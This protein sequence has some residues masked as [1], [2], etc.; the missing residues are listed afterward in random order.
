MNEDRTPC[1]VGVGK[2]PFGPLYR[3]LDP[4]RSAYGLAAEALESALADAGMERQSIDSVIVARLPSY[5]KFCADFGLT[6]VRYANF[7]SGGG[8]QSGL[9][10]L[11]AVA[12]I[13]S[14]QA[15]TVAC[16]YGNN[17][18]SVRV[19]YGGAPTPTSRYDDPYGMTSNG[20]Y[21]AMMFRRHQHEFG[22]PRE[23]LAELA[24]SIRSNAARNPDA[25]MRTP[26]TRDDYFSQPCI[27]DPLR[28]YDY[29]LIN[30][31]GVAYLVTTLARARA[32]GGVPVRVLGSAVTG[33]MSYFYGT[34]DH[35]Y[36]CLRRL[37]QSVF[38][39]AGIAPED[40]DVAQIYDNYTPAIVFALEGMGICGRGESG[41]WILDGRHRLGSTLPLNTAGGHLSEGYMQG[42]GHLVEAVRQ[43]RGDAGDNQVAGCEFALDVSCTPICAAHILGR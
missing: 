21:Y 43:V 23:T 1:I 30:D 36:A 10:L 41:R 11:Q 28:L 19:N 15:E 16:V 32:L 22:T 42:W 12:L 4:D 14:G 8:F 9:A 5:L 24:I 2:T 40:L 29:C 6:Q 18:R 39:E 7:Q 38:E 17:G 26:I 33:H 13:R 34:E 20:A 3:Q 35:W 31:G 25:V 27:V 37:G